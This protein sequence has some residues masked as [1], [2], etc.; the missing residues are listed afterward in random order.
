[1][2]EVTFLRKNSDRWKQ[3]EEML[4]N[5]K[6]QEADELAT[7]YI[8]LTNDLA[9]AQSKYPYSRTTEY[10]NELTVTAHQRL[11]RSKRSDRGTIQRFWFYEIPSLYG[12]YRHLLIISLITFLVAI[13]IG[14]FSASTDS[15]FVRSILGDRYVNMT[16][17]NIQNEDPLAVYKDEYAFSMF[18]GITLN[19][20]RVS[21]LAFVSG[22]LTSLGTG[23]LL[24]SN[25]IM[26]GSFLQFFAG[27][28]LLQEALLVVFIHGTLELSAIVIAGAAGMRMGNSLLFPG[29][30]TR[31]QSFLRGAREGAKMVSAL[32]PIFIVA[33]FLEAFVTRYTEMPIWLSLTIILGSAFLMI[34]YFLWLPYTL[35]K[36]SISLDE[37]I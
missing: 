16:I 30:Y 3:F 9:F 2:R 25:G 37:S 36:Q 29:T 26:V 33:G 14:A 1:M 18:L 10:L 28:A 32:V 27:Y 22:L 5:P 12:K 35:S 34:Y 19:N 7:L 23:F 17:E 24:F 8:K 11:Y 15:D 20:V 13:S 6:E 31:Y 4:S 21:F